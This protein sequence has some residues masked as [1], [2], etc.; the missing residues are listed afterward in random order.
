VSAYREIGLSA[1]TEGRADINHRAGEL[2]QGTAPETM[3]E[4][5]QESASPLVTTCG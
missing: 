5:T 2:S 1:V 4:T 3:V